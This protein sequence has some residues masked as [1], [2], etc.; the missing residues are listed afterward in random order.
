[1]KH[2]QINSGKI[3]HSVLQLDEREVTRFIAQRVKERTLSIL[4]SDLNHDV[5][6][7]SMTE[8]GT[9]QKVLN[10]MGFI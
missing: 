3:A 1:M 5:L 8:R 6:Y 9:A 2:E 4:I 7:G 10:R